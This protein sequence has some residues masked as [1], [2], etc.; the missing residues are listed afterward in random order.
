MKQDNVFKDTLILVTGDHGNQFAESPRKKGEVGNRTY[1]E[2]I[3]VPMILS[4]KEDRIDKDGMCDSMSMS[5]TFLDLLDVPL[6]KTYK[7]RSIFKKANK[8]VISEN[9]GSGN[10]DI[11]KR[12]I[13][14]T[15]TTKQYKLMAVLQKKILQVTKLFCLEDDPQELKNIVHKGKHEKLIHHLIKILY[16]E[17]KYLFDIRKIKKLRVKM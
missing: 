8:F 6:H 11:V 17:R 16:L 1:Y 14:F 9:C 7:G 5:A 13:Y 3:Q 12:D 10:A 4:D 2:D 15:L